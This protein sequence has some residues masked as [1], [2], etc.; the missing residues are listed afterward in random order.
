MAASP[1]AFSTER[2]DARAAQGPGGARCERQILRHRF[3][4]RALPRALRYAAVDGRLPEPGTR[5][6][7]A[8]GFLRVSAP[9]HPPGQGA[10]DD[11]R[12]NHMPATAE[13]AEYEPL[14]PGLFEIGVN[15]PHLIGGRRKRDGKI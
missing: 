14:A 2:A 1:S 12:K 11:M 6:V 8:A 4:T 3:H 15:G 7:A 5:R 13:T 10:C 9:R